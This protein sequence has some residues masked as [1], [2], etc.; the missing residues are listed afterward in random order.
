LSQPWLELAESTHCFGFPYEI[1]RQEGSTPVETFV[2]GDFPP[3][4]FIRAAPQPAVIET[5]HRRG[6]AVVSYQTFYGAK[7]D[8][9]GPWPPSLAERPELAIF[10][11]R[12]VR[13]RTIFADGAYGLEDQCELCPNCPEVVEGAVAAA[14]EMAATGIDGLFLDCAFGYNPCHGEAL[15][16]H[17]HLYSEKDIAGIPA[18]ELKFTPD[19]DTPNDDALGLYAF[20]QLLRRVRQAVE[21][22]KPGFVL[23]ANTCCWPFRYSRA[24]LRK[25]VLFAP[26]WR[27]RTP[28]VLWATLDGEMVE[29]F[30]VLPR[31]LLDP[32]SDELT[33]QRWQPWDEWRASITL[34]AGLAGK[35]QIVLPYFGTDG[36]RDMAFFVYATA[37]LGDA[38]WETSRRTAGGE[39]IGLEL[40]RPLAPPETQGAAWLRRFDRGAVAVNPAE[41]VAEVEVN[42]AA[43]E[44]M[45]L[46]AKEIVSLPGERLRVSL[47]ARSG[48]IWQAL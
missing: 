24:P 42:L 21:A 4:R 23:I 2:N 39:F 17:D 3:L 19:I 11:R 44:A 48:K 43:P 29:S 30:M 34:P 6:I 5:A 15:R 22:I 35:R 28:R 41:Q 7:L 36:D 45:D 25:T 37:K 1:G 31:K 33:T 26:S 10:D 16:V 9:P 13:Q 12:G 38:I 18:R 40:G 27:R 20:A 32:A 47:P 46:Y 8:S 14:V